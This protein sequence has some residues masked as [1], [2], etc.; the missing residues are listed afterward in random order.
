MGDNGRNS[1]IKDIENYTLEEILDY[2]F[3]H[4]VR[5]LSNGKSN[6]HNLYQIT[7][8]LFE[9]LL[10]K[11]V[12]EKADFNQSKAAEILGINRNTL[13]KKLIKYNII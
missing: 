12:F 2:K 5:H 9:K 10:I 13:K 7:I 6:N 8:E 3:D 11:K 1:S 4:L